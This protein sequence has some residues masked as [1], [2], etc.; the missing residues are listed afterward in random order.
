MGLVIRCF[1]I[2]HSHVVHGAARVTR[3]RAVAAK[4]LVALV[5]AVSPAASAA[6]ATAVSPGVGAWCWFADPRAL[7]YQDTTVFGWVDDHGNVTVGD[8]NGHRFILDPGDPAAAPTDVDDHDNPAFYVRTDGRLTAFW[9]RH[10]GDAMYERTTIGLD[11]TQWGAVT[12]LPANPDGPLR[13]YTYPNPVRLGDDL[14]LFWSGTGFS[15]TWSVSHDDGDTWSQAHSLFEIGSDYVRYIKYRVGRD[16]IHMAW[17]LSHPRLG[18]SGIYHAVI[19]VDGSIIRQGGTVVGHLG[20]PVPPRSGD[21]VYEPGADGKAWIHDI[22]IGA[23]G[24][25]VI[26]FATF[27]T[28]TD[29]HYHYARWTEDRWADEMLTSAGPSFNEDPNEAWYSGGIT[30]V[31]DDTAVVYLSRTL[32]GQFEIERWRRRQD[33]WVVLAVTS[34]SDEKNVRPFAVGGGVAWMRGR[35]PSYTGF[36]TSLMWAPTPQ[37][38]EGHPPPASPTP[39]PTPTPSPSPSRAPMAAGDT[40]VDQSQTRELCG[41]PRHRRWL[42]ALT[43]REY[44]YADCL[45]TLRHRA[46]RHGWRHSSLMLAI[47]QK[48]WLRARMRWLRLHD[49]TPSRRVRRR[50]LNRVMHYRFRS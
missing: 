49:T 41:A 27:P 17:S 44:R 22:A 37:G 47:E 30:I 8:R 14:Y 24:S 21:V 26:V 28:V 34:G 33:G 5:I 2:D 36:Q 18:T 20:T 15:A 29:H 9:S 6:A 13:S 3:T 39:T 1:P 42:V 38:V 4:L 45:L 11:V 25:P 23:N 32:G 31:P 16:G 40:A 50:L 46:H 43:D 7:V 48:R 35:Y 10:G 12:N 19:R